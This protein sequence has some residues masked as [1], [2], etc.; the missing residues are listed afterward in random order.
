MTCGETPA[1]QTLTMTFSGTRPGGIL[2]F[3][4]TLTLAIFVIVSVGQPALA[5]VPADAMKAAHESRTAA[6]NGDLEG[7]LRLAEHAQSQLEQTTA[8]RRMRAYLEDD[9]ASYLMKLGRLDE[10]LARSRAA[11]DEIARA[12]GEDVLAH[13]LLATNLGAIQ[14]AFGEVASG[15]TT[16]QTA[17][18]KLDE[19]VPNRRARAAISIS[20]ALRLQSNLTA[21]LEWIERALAAGPDGEVLMRA[22]VARLEVLLALQRLPQVRIEYAQLM[23]S[24]TL[25][26]SESLRLAADIAYRESRLLDAERLLIELRSESEDA[27]RDPSILS[28]LGHIQILTG[29]L[30]EA[31]STYR[32][33]LARARVMGMAPNHPLLGRSLHAL[34]ITYKDLAEYEEA[35]LLYRRA[36]EVLSESLGSD[37]E[38]VAR[39]KLEHS[40]LLSE[41]GQVIAAQR[42][43]RQAIQALASTNSTEA[44]G[45]AH[46][47]LGFALKANGVEAEAI[48]V[49]AT[50]LRY[51]AQA[52]GPH[53]PD[54]PPGL[55]ASAELYL[56]QGN[57]DA[58]L[59]AVN[60]AIDIQRR[61][62]AHTLGALANALIT[63]SMVELT[64]KPTQAL[65]TAYE[66]IEV[67]AEELAQTSDQRFLAALGETRGIFERYLHVTDRF[68]AHSS[69]RNKM[70]EAAQY[71]TLTSVS[72]TIAQAA[73][74]AAGSTAELSSLL[75]QRQRLH[76]Q[77]ATTEQKFERIAA[78]LIDGDLDPHRLAALN[79]QLS[80]VS[81]RIRQAYPAFADHVFPRPVSLQQAQS[82]LNADEAILTLLTTAEATYVF[83]IRRDALHVETTAHTESDVERMV[84][85]IRQSIVFDDTGELPEFEAKTAH[86]L[87][88]VL[89]APFFAL[90]QDVSHLV[91][92][93]DRA[94]ISLPLGLLITDPPPAGA[95]AQDL[96]FVQKR[97]AISTLPSLSAFVSLRSS[98]PRSTAPDQLLGVGDPILGQAVANSD[99]R[100]GL[101]MIAA[102][103]HSNLAPLP[104]TKLELDTIGQSFQRKKLLVQGAA[105]ESAL[106]RLPNLDRFNVIVFATHGLLRNDE[107]G[108]HEPALV[109]T[110][111]NE[112]DG[113]L[114]TGEISNLTLNADWVVLSACNTAGPDGSP[115]AAG[116]SGLAKAFFFAGARALLVSHWDV[117]STAAVLITTS[118]I[119]LNRGTA[120]LGKAHALKHTLTRFMNGEF[121]ERGAHPAYWAPFVLV[122]DGAA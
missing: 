42:S 31:Q 109:L 15:L 87:Y 17:F 78:G 47:A 61:M 9:R 76:R 80:D 120:K 11:V 13:G 59:A 108:V 101:G 32:D 110:P 19:A 103:V 29:R 67:V 35:D 33:L 38:A 1:C 57:P 2:S 27:A 20:R 54:L 107:L 97:F 8:H 81:Q 115:R 45:L 92:V 112:E 50:A 34:A 119:G 58:A 23:Q 6:R 22:T 102:N 79:E 111:D 18:P 82:E 104:K 49:F 63:K 88:T 117:N 30:V 106:Y 62:G 24:N 114:S 100:A 37:S 64:M 28:R 77:I 73:A 55:V 93:P 70:L 84:T 91:Y 71:P 65:A 56:S 52:E 40:L 83:L 89:L 118:T 94:L 98:V 122:G 60:R 43:A 113:L 86:E 66:A 21:A 7:A 74:R 105:T 121:G 99:T 16:L 116:L 75:E 26:R 68:R 85:D 39:S 96:A 90:M 36:I 72:T 48:D 46:S 41:R 53:S 44:L 51:L 12:D 10:A 95:R 3:T 69:V 25:P 4:L 5:E 14:V